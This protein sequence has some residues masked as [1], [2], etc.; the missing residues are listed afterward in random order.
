VVGARL[1]E[2]HG[3]H[4]EAEALG[5][6]GGGDHVVAAH[7]ARRE[8]GAAA[9]SR[10]RQQVLQLAHLVPAV[11]GVA[12]IVALDPQALV[13]AIDRRRQPIGQGHE[14]HEVGQTREPREQGPVG[15]LRGGGAHVSGQRPGFIRRSGSSA[16]LTRVSNATNPGSARSRMRRAASAEAL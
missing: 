12:E 15:R 10:D 16:S 13:D 7:G 5:V 6:H 4:L 1:R 11:A 8:H 9:P 2:A 3:L 14:R